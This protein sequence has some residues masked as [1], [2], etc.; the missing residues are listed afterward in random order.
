MNKFIKILNKYVALLIIYALFGMPWHYIRFF[1][2]KNYN[3]NPDSIINIDSIPTYADYL[4]CIIVIIL[5]IIDFK[6]YNLKGVIFS[7]IAALFFPLLGITIL[8]ILLLLDEKKSY[9]QEINE[10]M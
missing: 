4:L 3:Y 8:A 5:L 6:K 2:L 9:E 1:F 7:C 10:K